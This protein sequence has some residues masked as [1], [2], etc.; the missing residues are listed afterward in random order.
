MKATP[1]WTPKLVSL[2]KSLHAAADLLD[3]S[4]LARRAFGDPV[5]EFYVHTAR[6]EVEA[7]NNAVTDWERARYFERI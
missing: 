5:V 6:L 2:P 3:R 7:F 1:T 4:L